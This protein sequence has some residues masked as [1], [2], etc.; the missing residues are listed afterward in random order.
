MSKYKI[1]SLTRRDLANFMATV[2]ID[3]RFR[4]S[5]VMFSSVFQAVWGLCRNERI[6]CSFATYTKKGEQSKLVLSPIP[7]TGMVKDRHMVVKETDKLR[8]RICYR[9]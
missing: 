9:G 6:D 1:E 2:L 4:I 8:L 3:A 7:D 5:R